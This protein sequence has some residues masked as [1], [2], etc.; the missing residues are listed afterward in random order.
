MILVKKGELNKVSIGLET[1]VCLPCF[2]FHF[3]QISSKEE[4]FF[5]P[6]NITNGTEDR[7]YEFQ[8]SAGTPQNLSSTPPTI[9]FEYEGQY[10]VKIYAQEQSICGNLDPSLSTQF[11]WDGRAIVQDDCP[12]DLFYQYQSPNEDN[13]N[14]I[15]ISDDE[16]CPVPSPS[17]SVTPTNTP[18]PSV[19]SSVTP[20]PSITPTITPTITSSVTPVV[21]PT[22]TSTPTV[23]PSI[24]PTITSSVTPTLTPTQTPSNTPRAVYEF[25]VEIDGTLNGVCGGSGG[26]F[27]NVYGE[28][29][30]FQNNTQLYTNSNLTNLLT[31][32]YF[33]FDS[34]D[35][36]V[37]IDGFGNVSCCQIC[38]SPTPTST[39]TPT[40]TPTTSVTP[41]ITPTT[42][43]TPTLTST[44]TPT[45]TPSAIGGFD[46]GGGFGPTSGVRGNKIYGSDLYV[47]GGIDYYNFSNINKIAQLNKTTAQLNNWYPAFT[48]FGGL[49]V[50]DFLLTTGG[51]Y[52]MTGSFDRYSGSTQ[53]RLIKLNSDLTKD[54]T[55]NIGIGLQND[56]TALYYNEITDRLFVGGSFVG[57]NGDSTKA[58]LIKVDGT[59]GAIDT[60][61]PN[62]YFGNA[63]P[64][65]ILPDGNGNLYIGGQFTIVTGTTAQN[66]LVYISEANGF[67][68]P[69][70]NIG[71][72]FNATPKSAVLDKVNNRL[73]I[74]GQFNTY[75]GTSAGGIVCL[76]ATTGAIDA[77]FNYGTGLG[78]GFGIGIT[79]LPNGD[80]VILHN[81][82][83]F[84]GVLSNRLSRVSSG[85]TVN[86]TFQTNLGGSFDLGVTQGFPSQYSITN[87][88]TY[89]YIT[90]QFTSFNGQNFNGLVRLTIDGV[91]D[92]TT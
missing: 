36:I 83:S 35:T 74:T 29:P 71:T 25:P 20:T 8:F 70:F 85:G 51:S 44:P 56:S 33:R 59:T 53:Q 92:S 47:F 41:T 2:L 19:T 72:G 81:S 30:V 55:F 39:V 23:T 75:N 63:F 49:S 14:V 1:S 26:V 58:R 38:P 77:G 76:N 88:G 28:N 27:I 17:P 21:S 60:S 10:W 6:E 31:N 43:L 65:W 12:P 48:R 15:Y 67:R 66:R 61:I 13:A 84:N 3:T 82:A 9:D 4:Y 37:V 86:T 42:S 45:P 34:T 79:Q 50:L 54:T 78:G 40:M 80:L 62:N 64:E 46:V 7:Y 89:L 16:I 11:V 52:Y 24:T 87:D 32:S 57:Y 5:I 73:Y 69:G 22:S 18:T 90:Y 91:L 68:V